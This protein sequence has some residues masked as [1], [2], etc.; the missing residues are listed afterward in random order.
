MNDDENFPAISHCEE[1]LKKNED[2]YP[3]PKAI[4][5]L[6]EQAKTDKAQALARELLAVSAVKLRTGAELSD[7]LRLYLADC[8]AAVA[9]H[10]ADEAGDFFYIKNRQGRQD[11]FDRDIGIVCDVQREKHRLGVYESTKKDSAFESVAKDYGLTT[12]TI[13]G[14]WKKWGG[15]AKEYDEQGILDEVKLGKFYK[16]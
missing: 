3:D 9:I 11:N 7:E 13:K 6:I 10:H 14:I 12:R 2:L 16:K 5:F 1:I 15:V 4:Q 8:L